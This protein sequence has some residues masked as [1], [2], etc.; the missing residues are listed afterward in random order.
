MS[1]ADANNPLGLNLDFLFGKGYLWARDERLTDWISLEHL[2][3][4]IPD[5]KFPFDARG[6][7]HRFRNTRCLVRE[8][9][10]A[11]SEVGFGD[12]LRQA[13]AEIQ[14]YSDI[15]LHF[16]DGAAHV[17]MKVKSLGT[18]TYVSFRCGVIPPEPAR[19]DEVH[20]SI[21]DYRSYGPLPYPARL[22]VFDLITRLL[23][24][25]AL[26]PP[27]RGESFTVGIAGD[28]LR[29]RPLK[30]MLLNI[31]P[32]VGWK[33]PNL[34]NVTL[35]AAEIRP[36]LMTLKAASH[37]PGWTSSSDLS[38]AATVEGAR[39]LAAY[40]AKDLYAHADEAL[41]GR[42]VRQALDLYAT[43]RDSFGAHPE[44]LVRM[45]DC[46]LADP[47][48]A[49]VAHAESLVREIEEEDPN[50]I[51]ALQFRPVLAL[52][53]GRR[54][55]ALRE[56]D[57]LSAALKERRETYD[58]VLCEL[59]AAEV[60]R[61]DDPDGAAEKLRE[62]LKVSPRNRIALE[63]LKKLYEESG[64][65]IGL[66][67]VLKRLTGVY[68][69]RESLTETYLSLARHLMDRQGEVSEARVYLER[70]LRLDPAQLDALDTLGQ[71]YL[72]SGEPLRAL[73]A[74]GSAARAAEARDQHQQASRL[75]F[76]ISQIWAD[77]VG[78]S[79]QALVSVRRA[80]SLSDLGDFPARER[81]EQLEFAAML[82]EQRERF[83]EAI[84]YWVDLLPLLERLGEANSLDPEVLNE[85]RIRANRHLA[86]IYQRRGRAD[87]AATHL[88]RLLEFEPDDAWAFDAL[89]GHYR[90]AGDPEQLLRLYQ[91]AIQRGPMEPEVGAE[92]R[93]KTAEVYRVLKLSDEAA[94]QL[95]EA[96]KHKP[97]SD[98]ARRLL[99][100][101]LVSSGKIE[102]LRSQLRGILVR[103]NDAPSRYAVLL[104]LGDLSLSQLEA[105][106]EAFE[107]YWEAAQLIP[108][109]VGATLKAWR[110]LETI[111]ERYGA[112]AAVLPDQ[113]TAVSLLE[114]VLMRIVEVTTE[115]DELLTALRRLE[116][117]RQ[118]LGDEVGARDARRRREALTTDAPS[119]DVDE[120]LDE[121]L[122]SDFIV[123][124]ES[125][126]AA[127]PN[128]DA[129]RQQLES[130]L[131]KP[132]PLQA[133]EDIA[134]TSVL[135]RVLGKDDTKA[136]TKPVEPAPK[137]DSG[138]FAR[139]KT[140]S[141]GFEPQPTTSINQKDTRIAQV[142]DSLRQEEVGPKVAALRSAIEA[143]E[144]GEL[145][146][147]DEMRIDWTRQLGEYLFYDLED[148]EG[149]LPY[150]EFV[151]N[152]DPK[153]HGAR[154]SLLNALESIYED[155]GELEGRIQILRD[156][157]K[158]AES[159]DMDT[160]FRLLIAQLVW[161]HSSSKEAVEAELAPVLERD[162]RHE[163][164]HR[165]LAEVCSE[166]QEWAEAAKHL[167]VVLA[168]SA[169]GLDAVEVERDLAE[170]LLTKLDDAATALTHF[171]NV[172][173]AAPGDS[174]A[175]ESMRQA[176]AAMDNWTGYA[177][178]LTQELGLL[179]AKPGMDITQA[180]NLEIDS[181]AIPLRIPASQ[182]LSDLADV[183][184]SELNG[185]RA[186]RDLWGRVHL[187][188]PEHVEALERRI[189]LDRNLD[190]HEDLARDLES[191]ADLLLDPQERF[192]TLSEAARLNAKLDKA[193]T[194][195]TLYTQAL[196]IVENEP[197]QPSNVDEV[198][199]ALQ[200][201]EQK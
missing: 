21:Y 159:T 76:H 95:T 22:L 86:K 164:A 97:D 147:A 162:A 201:L 130:D 169:G 143:I 172:I 179:L 8:I 17:S 100:E 42:D 106:K 12:L 193:D 77:E 158:R 52:V 45:L 177:E 117:V 186:A 151:R 59:A 144:A 47:T 5:L 91:E 49:N 197:E 94:L 137:E 50:D 150:L 128:V 120:R 88:R 122:N 121:L 152:Q 123:D 187:L 9:E 167:K 183:V 118:L 14:G 23:N 48:P 69:D 185:R 32:R 119:G 110:A 157:L 166:S 93:I 16:L 161:E 108:T 142:M 65:K 196:A 33:L 4:E 87:A 90:M 20:L 102:T 73:K 114:K 189:D 134:P 138:E 66:E 57:K 145:D 44:L 30:L 19:A 199:R 37:E 174:K 83:D 107:L 155:R 62:V 178:T 175:L 99:I 25:P 34:S 192:A 127:K 28:I 198:R 116:E 154:P 176:Y 85:G 133:F 74:F 140:M 3:M 160:V 84:G 139:Q 124:S 173:E 129:F 131:K 75:H 15:D 81:L 168:E 188:W 78:D 11:S 68:T 27:G 6:G 180:A 146:I 46:L 10:I 125:K 13:S 36:G 80:L 31:F 24:S 105:P 135:G 18:D 7:L 60:L 61:R 41:F 51:R 163:A 82:C 111:A 149:A 26:R 38:A 96:L 79:G 181:V 63:L 53:S 182:I 190:E 43:A 40:E 89:E 153:N 126:P 112:D 1:Q 194:A 132:Q 136:K 171:K 92:L 72:M 39:A 184:E 195:R 64:E 113:S 56:F 29:L 98:T 148:S 101:V 104:D 200:A 70:V 109:R 115:S 58:W 71:S 141:G 54:A 165:L 67:E 2:R 156:R 55:D 191:Y 103:V 35:D 170:V